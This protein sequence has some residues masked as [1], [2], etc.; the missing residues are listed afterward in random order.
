MYYEK[1]VNEKYSIISFNSTATS[2][3]ITY[4]SEAFDEFV[5]SFTRE[6]TLVVFDTNAVENSI[7]APVLLHKSDLILFVFKRQIYQSN[8]DELTAYAQKNLLK[9]IAIVV[10]YFSFFDMIKFTVKRWKKR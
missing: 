4:T 1:I 5:K 10:N 8:I 3:L 6:N 7:D 2:N 9:E